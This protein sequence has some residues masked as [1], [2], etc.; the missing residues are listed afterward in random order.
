VRLDRIGGTGKHTDVSSNTTLDTTHCG[1]TVR[2]D[3]SGGARNITLP[4][5]PAADDWVAVKKIDS[6]ANRVTVKIG[7]THY[8]WLSAQ[9]DVVMFAY[10]GGAWTPVWSAIVPLVD[11]FTASGTWTKPPLAGAVEV[12]AIGA[13]SGGGAGRRGPGG[14]GRGGGCGG[15]S[16]VLNTWSFAAASLGATE[17]V[18]VGASGAGAAAQTSDGA[19]GAAG[20]AGGTSSFG[21]RLVAVAGNAG[22]GGSN[23]TVSGPSPVQPLRGAL[24]LGSGNSTVTA[25]SAAPVSGP[26]AGTGG[27][28]G[29]VTSG[30]VGLDGADGGGGSIAANTVTAGGAHGAAGANNGS[31]GTSISDTTFQFGGGGGGGGGGNGSG[32]GGSGG[33]GGVPGGGGGGGGASVN[34]SASGAGG[35]GA[36]GEVRV[37]TYF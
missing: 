7:S 24:S 27:N 1:R 28:G 5:S 25:A 3:A 12:I 33:A 26:G 21:T 34:G 16:G 17:T 11:L 19:D 22:P 37:T 35:A 9:N 32:A 2:V 30:N 18:T 8:A 29:P 13:G 4:S 14:G 10:W 6:S 15:G 36:R 31:V 20:S 23:A